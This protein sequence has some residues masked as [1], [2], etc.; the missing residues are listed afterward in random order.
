MKFSSCV[1]IACASVVVAPVTSFMS[2]QPTRRSA[3]RLL[4][5]DNDELWGKDDAGGEP[6]TPQQ[7]SQA[8]PFVARPKLLDGTLPGDVGFDPFGLAGGDRDSLIRQREAELKHGR[9]AMLAAVGWPL[10]ELFDKKIAAALKLP[11]VLTKTGSSPSILNGGLEKIDAE[12]WVLVLAIAGLAELASDTTKKEKEQKASYV[13]GDCGFDPFK[14]FP[15]DPRKRL[16]MQTKEIKNG[17]V[18]MMAVLGYVVQE[19]LYRT[20]VTAETPFFFSPIW[21]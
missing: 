12:Y 3:T 14:L 4:A 18:A 9:L 15:E 20:P 16:A 8:L 10:A 2:P 5:E 11:D 17:R 13:P 7:M 1:A 6:S 21:N 19:A